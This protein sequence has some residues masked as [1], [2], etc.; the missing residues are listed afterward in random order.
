M[1]KKITTSFRI[2]EALKAQLEDLAMERGLTFS[3]LL[4]KVLEEW[5]DRE[6]D[7]IP[8]RTTAGTGRPPIYITKNVH[9]EDLRRAADLLEVMAR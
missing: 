7:Y 4:H 5:C 3:K 9:P 8:I 1:S 2:D 6:N